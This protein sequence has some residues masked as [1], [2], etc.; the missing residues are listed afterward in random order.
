MNRME[1][2]N[3]KPENREKLLRNVSTVNILSATIFHQVLGRKPKH[4]S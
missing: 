4:L 3:G 1:F 2:M